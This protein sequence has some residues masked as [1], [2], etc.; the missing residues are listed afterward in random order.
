M[1]KISILNRR[2]IRL[3][4]IWVS[5]LSIF[6]SLLVIFI[7]VSNENKFKWGAF[8]L[9][10][11]IF[12]Y[13]GLYIWAITR[14]SRTLHINNS[15]LEIRVGDIFSI[16]EEG[17]KVI[18]FNE[19]FD[20]I[21]DDK[22]ISKS[23]LNGQFIDRF[24]DDVKSLDTLIEQDHSLIGEKLTNPNSSRKIGK[25]EKYKL[26]SIIPYEKENQTFLLTAF[27][28]FDDSNRAY[29]SMPDYLKF[30]ISFWDSVDKV[31]SGRSIILPL[32]GSGIT[33]FTKGYRDAQDKELLDIII[34]TFKISRIKF[35]YP[36]K[37]I[38]LIYDDKKNKF[39]FFDINE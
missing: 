7:D 17:L 20:T 16:E 15:T 23:S 13:I 18:A 6:F 29:L 38:I 22:L 34:W 12:V 2:L 25:K 28:H 27:S 3:Y 4:G 30:L 39:N 37:V 33:R 32:F 24:V 21:V 9:A 14:Y 31:Y 36:A 26:G 10:T 1:N 8:L 11:F 35:T 19:Y 5:W